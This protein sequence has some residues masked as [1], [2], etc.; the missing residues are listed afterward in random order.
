MKSARTIRRH[1]AKLRKL[2]ETTKNPLEARI[3][4]TM[5]TAL[6]WVLN[7]PAY[8]DLG[9]MDKEAKLNTKCLE[10]EVEE[11]QSD[12]YNKIIRELTK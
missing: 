4:Y 12:K 7:H 2:C 1:I 6:K 11:I 8:G 9:Y 5:E 10:R 3:A